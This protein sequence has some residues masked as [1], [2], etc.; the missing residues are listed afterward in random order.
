MGTIA[1]AAQG[2]AAENIATVATTT[3]KVKRSRKT[4]KSQFGPPNKKKG[5][6]PAT[7]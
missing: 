1:N 4:P 3:V 7:K 6:T 2:L 5:L